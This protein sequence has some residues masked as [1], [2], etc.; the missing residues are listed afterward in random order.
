MTARWKA[1]PVGAPTGR[2]LVLAE[3]WRGQG[4]GSGRR[5]T[6]T[7]WLMGCIKSELAGIPSAD[8]DQ[9]D[10]VSKSCANGSSIPRADDTLTPLLRVETL[11][12][13]HAGTRRAQ[14]YDLNDSLCA[15]PAWSSTVSQESFFNTEEERRTWR[16]RRK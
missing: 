12:G 4:C 3:G 8:A 10:P 5:R 15:F 1:L 14:A 9:N 13:P 2:R 16:S 6:G 7:E 11:V